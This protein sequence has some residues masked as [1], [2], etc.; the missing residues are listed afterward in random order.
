MEYHGYI[1]AR[2]KWKKKFKRKIDKMQSWICNHTQFVSSPLKSGHIYIID[3][4]IGEVIKTQRILI[5]MPVRELH[6]ELIKPPSEGVFLE[7][8]QNQVM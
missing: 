6:N 4:R 2:K 1:N 5:Q 8:Y 3:N 7:R